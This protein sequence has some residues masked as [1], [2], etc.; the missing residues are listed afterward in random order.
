MIPSLARH[1]PRLL[2]SP[3]GM[4][5]QQQRRSWLQGFQRSDLDPERQVL[6]SDMGTA[7]SR[8]DGGNLQH[9][10]PSRAHASVADT[11]CDNLRPELVVEVIEHEEEPWEAD[12]E[13]GLVK[14]DAPLEGKMIRVKVSGQAVLY[15][16]GGGRL[17]VDPRGY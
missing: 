4:R 12:P 2:A 14:V 13:L 5:A 3:S 9:A 15:V 11:Q 6:A 8:G 17:V 7:F 16:G 10:L 1:R